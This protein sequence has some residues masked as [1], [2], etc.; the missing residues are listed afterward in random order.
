MQEWDVEKRVKWCE[1]VVVV[2]KV[3]EEKWKGM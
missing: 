1:V 2:T 3:E